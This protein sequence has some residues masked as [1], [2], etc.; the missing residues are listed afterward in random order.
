MRQPFL[1]RDRVQDSLEFG[2]TSKLIPA[3]MLM[4]DELVELHDNDQSDHDEILNGIFQRLRRLPRRIERH[5]T[6]AVRADPLQHPEG[7]VLGNSCYGKK[8]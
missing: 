5:R 2:L 7:V 8:E 6:C 3:R 1:R 4:L